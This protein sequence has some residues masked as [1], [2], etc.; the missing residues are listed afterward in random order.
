MYGLIPILLITE[1]KFRYKR[2][3]RSSNQNVD[4]DLSK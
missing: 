2:N 4:A 1:Q 3:E